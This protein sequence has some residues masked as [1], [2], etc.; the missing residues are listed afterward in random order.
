M[1]RISMVLVTMMLALFIL[2]GCGSG[3]KET[4]NDNE[5]VSKEDN[6][7]VDDEEVQEDEPEEEAESEET[8]RAATGDFAELI[9]YMEDK[10]EGTA[11]VLYENKESQVHELDGVTVSLDAYTL[12]ELNDFH[13]NFDIPFN[14][15][16]DGGV[17]IAQYTV[18]NELDQDVYYMPT[19]Y[20]SFTGADKAYNNYKELLPEEEQLPEKL[21][22]SND[23]TLKAGESVTG[24]YAYPFGKS[25]LQQ[26]LDVGTVAIEVPSAEAEKGDFGNPIGKDG[27][28]TLSLNE[29]GA[30]KVAANE[31][32][33]KD[34]VT[35]DDM[36][37]KKMLKEE[38]DIGES[39]Q[40][41]DVTV[42]L[43]GYQI[44]EF[45]PNEIE[46]PRFTDFNNGIVLLTAKFEL[47]N[48]GSEPINLSS[49]SSKLIVNDG[50]QY[51][52]DQGMLLNYRYGDLIEAGES[53]EYLQIYTLDKEQYDKIWKDKPIELEFGPIRGEEAKDLSKGKTATFEL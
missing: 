11:N 12:V 5:D 10:T 53:G 42:T 51:I 14:D 29:A 38:S 17:I 20:L 1:G 4:A 15:E 2:S 44:T 7:E 52:L 32:F 30:E 45:T 41:G 48:K 49:M 18:T 19:F 16:T 13:T 47:D 21:S 36:G 33:Y 8:N 24:Y 35:T 27:K 28:F 6:E 31:A 43:E 46:A 26:A 9:T 37:E 22:P 34:K 23:Y 39:E 50:S 25:H 3:E 40:L